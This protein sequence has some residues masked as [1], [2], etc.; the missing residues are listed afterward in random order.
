MQFNLLPT[1]PG[2]TSG[3]CM[4]GNEQ[5]SATVD[6]VRRERA[7]IHTIYYSK[8]LATVD[9]IRRE[10]VQIHTIYYNKALAALDTI[11]REGVK[12]YSSVFTAKKS[13]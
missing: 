12:E 3:L 2:V 11:M 4:A 10:R 13:N 5:T 7:N 1:G 6:I 9:A 8:P